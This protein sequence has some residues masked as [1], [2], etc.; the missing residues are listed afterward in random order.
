MNTIKVCTTEQVNKPF[1]LFDT[2]NGKYIK[3]ENGSILKFSS[4]RAAKDKSVELNSQ[5]L[6]FNGTAIDYMQNV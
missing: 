1:C 3:N 2:I 6:V 4:L 5:R